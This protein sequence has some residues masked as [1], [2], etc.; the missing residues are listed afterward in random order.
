M[1]KVPSAPIF[2]TAIL[3]ALCTS[4]PVYAEHQPADLEPEEGLFAFGDRPYHAAVSD[5]LL[6][7]APYRQCQMVFL[8]SFQREQAVYMVRGD[9]K[10]GVPATVVAVEMKDQLHGAMMK[11]LYKKGT[12]SFYPVGNAAERKALGRI[13]RAVR[14]HEAP[15]DATTANL[16]EEAWLTVLGRVRYAPPEGS[17]G[18]A[19]GESFHA[20]HYMRNVGYRTGKTWSPEVGT[21]AADLVAL[22]RTLREFAVVPGVEREAVRRKLADQAQR[23]V[24][25]ARKEPARQTAAPPR[26]AAR[27]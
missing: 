20:A 16:L 12:K 11:L 9:D 1:S 26:G 18:G 6:G 23:L 5:I 27:P 25:R 3:V 17:V 15:L 4:T 8:P 7:S 13:P 10:K 24:E 22:A 2:R 19:D 14:R 21:I